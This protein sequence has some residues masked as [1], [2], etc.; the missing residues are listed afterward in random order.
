[1]KSMAKRPSN[2]QHIS[3][4]SG[5]AL[6]SLSQQYVYLS[7]FLSIHSS[8]HLVIYLSIHPSI[9]IFIDIPSLAQ[10]PSC[11][12][13]WL[14]WLPGHSSGKADS[15]RARC[16]HR[17]LV[18]TA[19]Q[20]RIL[21]GYG[22][23]FYCTIPQHFLSVQDCMRMHEW[24]ESYS[25]WVVQWCIPESSGAGA[26]TYVQMDNVNRKSLSMFTWISPSVSLK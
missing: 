9:S 2:S 8:L 16:S 19:L 22:S 6:L 4:N 14:G 1:M 25:H 26:P 21:K 5:N 11:G 10:S 7:V 13:P 17:V 18:Q 15:S 23:D 20:L 3:L 12:W 24:M